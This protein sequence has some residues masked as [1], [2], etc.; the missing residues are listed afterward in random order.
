[1]LASHTVQ[2]PMGDLF[3]LQDDVA[4]RV[5]EELALPA[6]PAAP[7]P[8]TSDRP[9]NP[10]AYEL[11][12]RANEIART[13]EGLP[14]ARDLY[15]R[16]LAID[17]GFA[18]AW[19]RLGRCHRVI[20]KFIDSTP[21]SGRRAESAFLRA[22]ELNPRLT[23][24][25]K[26]YAGFEADIGQAERAMVRLLGEATR[27]GND[28]ELFAGLV[29]ACRYC[30]L[31]DESLAAHA[32]ARRLDPH[33]E[34]SYMETL[35]LKGDVD[36]LLGATDASLH[37]GADDGMRVIGLG[38]A[39][40][41]DEARRTLA[42]M[43]ERPRIPAFRTWMAHL[44]AWLEDRREDM[45]ATL[46]EIGG[47]AIFQDPE[48]VFQEGW[49]LCDVGEHARAMP[50]LDRALARRYYV[51]PTLVSWP[52]FDALRG[53]P[54]FQALLSDA[55]AGRARARVAFVEAGGERLLGR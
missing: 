1:V 55:E 17:P 28:P 12:L 33:I 8:I 31:F 27:H 41:R 36:R 3:A 14:R 11:Y 4:R 9:Q 40:R 25:H 47:L 7:T 26:Y 30:G 22:L 39:G 18:P 43:Q 51:A 32:E 42:E 15:E 46:D 49:L 37:A 44:A 19:A 38:L 54:G 34:T 29:H 6:S 16:A 23:I 10:R 50:Y 24:A 35:L 2:M 52:Q 53:D 20:G 5:R 21:D 45:F 48:A 13:Y